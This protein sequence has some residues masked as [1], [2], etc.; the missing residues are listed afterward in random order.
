MDVFRVTTD[1][2]I[3]DVPLEMPELGQAVPYERLHRQAPPGHAILGVYSHNKFNN[4]FHDRDVRRYEERK[5][6][7]YGEITHDSIEGRETEGEQSRGEG[8]I[9]VLYKT[10]AGRADEIIISAWAPPPGLI[11]PVADNR[12]GCRLAQP[13]TLLPEKIVPF[14][15]RPEAERIYLQFDLPIV[16]LSEFHRPDNYR[17]GKRFVGRGFDPGLDGDGRFDVGADRLPS[18]SG[19]GRVASR[20]AYADHNVIGE[21]DLRNL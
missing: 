13:F 12:A 6:C 7:W 5:G 19:Y 21:I 20:P 9:P 15:N 10:N 11:V 4:A 18:D 16:E 17:D 14:D 2:G 8:W 3:F 1:K